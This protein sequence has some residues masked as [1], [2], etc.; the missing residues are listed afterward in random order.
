[1]DTDIQAGVVTAVVG[2]W[3]MTIISVCVVV[4]NGKDAPLAA[5]AAVALAG[6]GVWV[7]WIILSLCWEKSCDCECD[8]DT[9]VDKKTPENE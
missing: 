2:I 8:A 4:L 9:A 5:I 6:G 3:L 7:T 1:V